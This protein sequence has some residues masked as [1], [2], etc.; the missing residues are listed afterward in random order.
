MS[1]NYTIE[2][3]ID[4]PNYE[5]VKFHWLYFYTLK[6]PQYNLRTSAIIIAGIGLSVS[7][8]SLKSQL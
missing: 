2:F 3:N 1:F 5:I 8:R 6:V 7:F 4:K